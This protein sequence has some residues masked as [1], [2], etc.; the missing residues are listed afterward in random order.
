MYAAP[1]REFSRSRCTAFVQF[2]CLPEARWRP[3]AEIRALP[4]RT[5][6]LDDVDRSLLG[7]LVTD[8][9]M[10]WA[11]LAERNGS[12]PATVRR[13]LRR[14]TDAEVL[15]FRCGIAA[16]LAG[17]PVPV[18][19]LARAPA[20]DIATVHRTLAA[21]PE[22]RLVAAVTG[23]D[24]LF[25]TLWFQDMATSSA[26]RR[27][28]A[29]GSPASRSPTGSWACAPSNAWGIGS[30]TR[31]AAPGSGRSPLVEARWRGSLTGP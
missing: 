11:E 13:R 5:L 10:G 1:G 19:F 16:P 29:R 6:G 7:E 4:A 17:R 3:A 2:R 26:A 21:L 12:S 27:R 14:L 8:G 31:A 9:R 20:R 24:S 30:T 22:C 28:S 23:P 25:A 18:S 15:T